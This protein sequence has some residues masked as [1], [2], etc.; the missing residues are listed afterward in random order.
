MVVLN[1][2]SSQRK[3]VQDG[4]RLPS[5]FLQY[6]SSLNKDIKTSKQERNPTLKSETWTSP[7]RFDILDPSGLSKSGRCANSG[8]GR[9]RHA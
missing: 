1:T 8:G 7:L 6:E 4:F 3:P 5:S 9:P 2:P